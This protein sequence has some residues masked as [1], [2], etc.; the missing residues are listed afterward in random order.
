VAIGAT[1]VTDERDGAD[2]TMQGADLMLKFSEKSYLRAEYAQSHARQNNASFISTDG[3]LTF[4]TQT[5]GG[6]GDSLDGDATAIE[7]RADLAE[8]GPVLDGDFQ[9]WWKTRDAG[10]SSGRLGQRF[11]VNDSGVELYATLSSDLK[12]VASHTDLER[13]Q[14]SRERVTRVQIEGRLGEVD[15]GVEVRHQNVE[16]QDPGMGAPLSGSNGATQDGE[17]LLIG[18]RLGYDLTE[19]TSIYA[20]GQTVADDRSD[21]QENDLFTL[22]I[23]MRFNEEIAVSLEASDGDRGSAL[24]GGFDYAL[25]NGLNFQASGGVGSG[26]ISQFATRYAIGEGHELYGSYAVDPDRT[27]LARNLLTLGQ[28]RA[29]GNGIDLFAESQFGKDDQFASTGHVFGL[30]FEGKDDW[31]FNTS[32]QFSEIDNLGQAFERRAVSLGVYRNRGDFKLGSQIEYREDEGADVHSRQYVTTNSFSRTVDDSSRWLG[33]LNLS[34]TEDELN[35]GRD[36]QF[37]ELDIAY[38]YRP[39]DN[40]KLNLISRYGFLYDLPTEGQA[41][42][43][44]DERSHLLSV[45]GIYD[46]QNRWE[47]AAK[48]AIRE[49]ER[50]IL[51]DAGPWKDFGLRMISARARYEVTRKWDALVEYRWL[52]DVDG[53]DNRHGALLAL[54]RQVND[55]MKIGVGFNFTDF[56]DELRTDSYENNGW[57]LDIVGM[58]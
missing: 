46:L 28:R 16:I 55:H 2:Y 12:V 24:V 47:L 6:L 54:Y 32:M 57:F 11:D 40:D 56:N 20:A 15:A 51:R 7:L 14:H 33:L 48:L 10:F 50:R 49:G 17:A 1:G 9:A 27:D 23:N 52:S 21:N 22:G 18:A 45:E 31:R 37:V 25:D 35:G 42:I 26:A 38:A 3:G 4:Q 30:E 13:E 29:F 5:S 39:T 44:P 58:Y 8:R 36:A 19:Q 53:K 43:R 34:W 41:T